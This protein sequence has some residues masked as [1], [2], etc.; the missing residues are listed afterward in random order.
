VG[1]K[2][3]DNFVAVNEWGTHAEPPGVF[4]WW[5]VAN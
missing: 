5:S 4:K 3:D 1:F 2:A